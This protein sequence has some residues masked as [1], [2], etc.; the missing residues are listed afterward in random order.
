MPLDAESDYARWIWHNDGYPRPNW[1]LL[2]E[3]CTRNFDADTQ[4]S[5]WNTITEEWLT[6]I[7]K[8][9][10]DS[11]KLLQTEH[12]NILTDTPSNTHDRLVRYY[13]KSMFKAQEVLGD[14]AKGPALG[15][16]AVIVFSN[17]GEYYDYTSYWDPGEGEFGGSAGSFIPMDYGQIVVNYGS[18]FSI[19]TTIAHE[20]A[21]ALVSHLPIPSWLNEGVAQ[22]IELAVCGVGGPILDIEQITK[23]RAYWNSQTIQAFWSGDSFHSSGDAQELSYSLAFILTRFVG[24]DFKA[25]SEFLN[26]ALFDDAGDAAAKQVLGKTLSELVAMF[27]GDGDWSIIK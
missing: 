10:G 8:K 1:P 16:D 21:H 11:S 19:D 25:L 9:L 12:F 15:R 13:E 2:Y 23:H 26:V 24:Q 18:G 6:G 7:G 14:A 4:N 3:W 22:H 5:I 20:L 17:P 27:L